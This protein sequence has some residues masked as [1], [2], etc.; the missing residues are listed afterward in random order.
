LFELLDIT[1][2][3]GVIAE[4]FPYDFEDFESSFAD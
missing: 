4:A 2:D 3:F 1:V